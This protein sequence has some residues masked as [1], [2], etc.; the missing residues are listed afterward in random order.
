VAGKRKRKPAVSG[1]STAR[2]DAAPAADPRPAASAA[3]AEILQELQIHQVELELRVE[4]LRRTELEL[5]AIR[6]RY[7][8][9]YEE[10]P[11]GYVTLDPS[12]LITQ[13]NRAA[14]RILGVPKS[15]LAARRFTASLDVASRTT[16]HAVAAE[17]RRSSEPR[18]FDALLPLS[19]GKPAWVELTLAVEPV[20]T[21]LRLT[22]VDVTQQR[23]AERQMRELAEKLISL[24]EKERSSVASTLHDDTGQQLTYLCILLE[25][26]REN[27]EPAGAAWIDEALAVARKVLVGIRRLSTSLS[28]AEIGRAGL[29]RAVQS[30]VSEFSGRTRIPVSFDPSGSFD[31]LPVDLSLAAYR[32]VQEALTNAARHGEPRHVEVSVHCGKAPRLRVEVRDDGRGFDAANVQMSL[33]LLS[34]RER[35][36]TAGGTLV[37]LSSPGHGTRIVFEVVGDG[38]RPPFGVPQKEPAPRRKGARGAARKTNP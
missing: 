11:V 3:P 10:A 27:T 7:L 15:S 16:F 28:P 36:R 38:D 30:M 29:L 4:E 22:L 34:M 12:N 35:A 33:G 37:L 32:I 13:S 21:E 26:A 31:G 1:F 23:T 14:A 19:G 6:D 2:D 8:S 25:R 17:V 5:Q 9:L 24:Q 20:S 18:S